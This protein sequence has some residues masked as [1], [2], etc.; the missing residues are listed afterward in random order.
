MPGDVAHDIRYACRSLAHNRGFA[1][2]AML[3]LA[4][5]IGANTAMFSIVNAVL[6]RPLPYANAERLA[7]IHEE[8]PA[9]VNRTRLTAENF[10]DLQRE[11]RS[12]ESLGGYVGTGF[13]VSGDGEPEL[14]I[15]QMVSAELF[16]ALGVRPILGRTF[17]PDENEGGRDRVVILSYALWQRKYAGDAAVIGRPITINASPYT[18]VGVMPPGFEFPEKRYQLW[19]P[20]AFR[21]NSLGM[22]N[23]SA[24]YLRVVGRMREGVDARQAAAELDTIGQRLA[25]AYPA[26]NENTTLRMTSLGEDTLGDVR[27]ALVLLLA[28]VAFVLLIACANVTNLLLARASTR[29]REIAVRMALG[30]G[31]LRLVRQLLTETMV[32]YSVGAIAGV[33]LAAWGLDVLVAISPADI[34]RLDQARLD[35]MTLTF[36]LVVTLVT[37]FAFGIAPAL[38][39]SRH[40]PVEHL[41]S[42]TRSAT[43]ARGSQRMRAGIVAAEVALSLMLLV[44][45]GLA[46]RSLMQLHNVDTGMELE[47]VLTFNVVGVENR[48]PDGSALRRF[49]RELLDRLQGQPGV[50][51]VGATTHLPLSGQDVEN[52]YTPEGWTP[53]SPSEVAVGGLRGIGGSYFGTLGIRIVA[54]RPFAGTDTERSQQVVMVN[55]QFARRYWPSQNP[56]GKRLK[57]GGPSSSDPWKTVVGV[58]EN[59]K[60][61]GPGSETR[62]EVSFPYDQLDE[63]F[64]IQWAR[65]ASVV[66]RS[67]VAPTMVLPVA[68]ETL[69]SIDP[70]MPLVEPRAMSDLLAEN[71]AQPRFRSLLLVSFSVLAG[72][73]AVVGIY[74]VV[75]YIVEQRAHEISV[76]IALGAQRRDVLGLVLRQ[77]ATPVVVGLLLGLAGA[78]AVGRAMSGLLFGITAL[79]P[80]TFIG[81]PLALATVAAIASLMPARRALSLD[82]ATSLRAE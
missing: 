18:I 52:G 12:F 66:I 56:I 79:D 33:M 57:M 25:T 8:H 35:V 1:A 49:Q 34:P 42:A 74:G 24:R 38:Q 36:T 53:P 73:L 28:A 62:P 11:A 48:Y 32:L 14:I 43:A 78:V 6:L 72:V 59:L 63:D 31:R 81:T 39:T 26:V 75:A 22:V 76:R 70:T 30:A 67:A 47:G 82:P 4:I 60:H 69:R 54:G 17:R 46:T 77:G 51:S 20:F 3:T 40:A 23:R 68:R 80:V 45:A 50:V 64:L 15:G 61:R 44:G 16:D 9:P 41:K 55:E 2:V 10:L 21:N 27:S 19:T 5:G 65:G 58:Y 37:G 29:E 13:T 71:V 7:V